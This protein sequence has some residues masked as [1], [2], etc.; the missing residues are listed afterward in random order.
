MIRRLTPTRD[1]YRIEK[2]P[3]GRWAIVRYTHGLTAGFVVSDHATRDLARVSKR[4]H[5]QRYDDRVRHV[6]FKK[7]AA[8]LENNGADN[9]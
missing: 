1:I 4:Q 7:L 2:R 6:T 5:E 3:H 9:D 8:E